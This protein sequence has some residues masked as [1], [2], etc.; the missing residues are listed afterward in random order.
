MKRLIEEKIARENLNLA[1]DNEKK[2]LRV[3]DSKLEK[4]I[5]LSLPKI[6]AKYKDKNEAA[7]DEVVYTVEETFKAM[8]MNV[9]LTGKEKN[10]F[11]V[12]RSTSFPTESAEGRALVYEEHTAETRIYFALDLG[13]SYRLIDEKMMIEEKWDASKLK[14]MA[15]F[16]VRSLKSPM[17]KDSVAGN[18]FYFINTK[19]GYDASRILN[20]TLLNDFHE[21]VTGDMA[22]AVPHQDVLI[23]ADLKNEKGY[24]IL[25]QMCMHFFTNGKIPITVMP[26]LYENGDFEPIFVFAS[27]RSK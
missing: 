24:D 19:D 26:F 13:N 5:T 4:G 2:E 25:G 11:P 14:Q 21:E 6:V 8:K 12:I 10:I 20:R 9:E 23:L 27:K 17:K 18:D 15:S 7:V 3:V 22:V 16:N 1:Y